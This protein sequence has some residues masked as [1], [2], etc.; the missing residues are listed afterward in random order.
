MPISSVT[1]VLKVGWTITREIYSRVQTLS[2]NNE[3]RKR[4]ER[5]LRELQNIADE[6]TNSGVEKFPA[7]CTSSLE[8]FQN[9]LDTCKRVCE[10]LYNKGALGKFFNAKSHAQDLQTLEK[11]L[12]NAR[13]SLQFA[14]TR[15]LLAQNQSLRQSVE[16]GNARVEAT[17]I[18]PSV[19][20]YQ[21]TSSSNKR[22][23]PFAI[24]KVD[25]SLNDQR[26][27]MIVK[28]S[29]E[30]NSRESVERYEVRYDDENRMIVPGSPEELAAG[31]D[32]E[33]ALSL[34]PPKVN[35]GHIYTV[36]VRA[37]NSQGHSEWS[38]PGRVFRFKNGPPNKPKKPEVIVISPT[39]VLA[40]IK[41]LEEK[42]ENG[43]PVNQ[44]VVEYI[45]AEDSNS[46][47]W[48]RLCCKIKQRRDNDVVKLAIK[49]LDPD[50]IYRFRVKMV[51][52]VGESQPSDTCEVFTTQLVPGPPQAV[53]ISSKRNDKTIKIRWKPPTL[54]PQA[55]EKYLVQMQKYSTKSPQDW[56]DLSTVNCNKLSATARSLETDTR[57]CFRVKAINNKNQQG[58]FSDV[59]EAETRYGKVGRVAAATSAFFGGT[60][61]GP[62]LGAATLGYV[63][64]ASAENGPDS[65]AGKVAAATAAGIG[66]GIGG[67]IL[68]TIGAP[69]VGGM[70]AFMAYKG[71]EGALTDLSPQSSEDEDENPTIREIWKISQKKSEEMFNKKK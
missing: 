50:S 66:G 58:D 44:C 11:E 69:F 30:L 23:K 6:I 21:G 48:Q 25:V 56:N 7:S 13:S 43:S 40:M 26:D 54:H 28:W 22:D 38:E 53:R 8:Q 46:P 20:V 67:A 71:M 3:F 5:N 32:S 60:L 68:G 31:D 39:E 12:E 9:S 29:D 17:V 18:H 33:F 62:L 19:G 16:E 36:Q 10:A 24:S 14:L 4:I 57:Y 52:E 55:V 47:V 59:V 2:E 37:V 64:G 27:L 15:V 61:G 63:A 70:A 42:D 1:S 35:P 41:R 34:G 51:N 49:S 45:A 65:K